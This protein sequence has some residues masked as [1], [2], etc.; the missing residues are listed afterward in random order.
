MRL[1]SIDNGRVIIMPKQERESTNDDM[2][3]AA[4]FMIEIM[5][6]DGVAVSSVKDGF[7]L[8]FRRNKLQEILDQNKGKEELVIFVQTPD[9]ARPRN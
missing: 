2:T 5:K 3:R 9:A 6:R 4:E 7:V 1:Q 8:M